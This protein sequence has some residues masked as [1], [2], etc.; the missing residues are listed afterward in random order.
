MTPETRA[1]LQHMR[2]RY[3]HDQDV[4]RL[5]DELERLDAMTQPRRLPSIERRTVATSVPTLNLDG[6]PGDE[7]GAS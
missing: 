5:F 2:I 3:R 1:R 4:Q 7:R 6:W